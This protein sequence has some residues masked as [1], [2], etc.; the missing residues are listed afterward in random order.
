MKHEKRFWAIVLVLIVCLAV[1]SY[2]CLSHPE[3]H[4]TK[5]ININAAED[6]TFDFVVD[7]TP[8]A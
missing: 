5:T 6:Y 1:Y 2:Y 7:P 4:I 3:T 8:F